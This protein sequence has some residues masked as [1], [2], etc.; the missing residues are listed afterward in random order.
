VNLAFIGAA[1]FSKNEAIL[2]KICENTFGPSIPIYWQFS[3]LQND[4]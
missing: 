3:A 4:I 1:M 2:L